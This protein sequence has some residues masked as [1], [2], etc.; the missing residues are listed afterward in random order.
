M[1]PNVPPLYF[2]DDIG[3][4]AAFFCDHPFGSWVGANDRYLVRRKFC[5]ADTLT[6]SLT[7]RLAPIINVGDMAPF[8]Q[9]IRVYA[10]RFVALVT[11]FHSRLNRSAELHLQHDAMNEP[12]ATIDPEL[13]VTAAVRG[14][15]PQN[16]VRAIA[17][18]NRIVGDLLGEWPS[19]CRPCVHLTNIGSARS[20]INGNFGKGI[21]I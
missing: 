1:L 14:G 6:L 16:A 11:C 18:W 12:I 20:R 3:T 17:G 10:K 21:T 8:S 15:C 4:D 7:A 13:T 9:V 2:A 5:A 19:S